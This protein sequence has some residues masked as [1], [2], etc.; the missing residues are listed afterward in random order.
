MDPFFNAARKAPHPGA[1]IVKQD[2]GWFPLKEEKRQRKTVKKLAMQ[3]EKEQLVKDAQ[4][5]RNKI[6]LLSQLIQSKFESNI[7]ALF[8]SNLQVP[9]P[10][11]SVSIL[12]PLLPRVVVAVFAVTGGASAL[13]LSLYI[14]DN[15]FLA[16]DS[17]EYE[18]STILKI[19]LWCLY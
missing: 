10:L 1:V 16:I 5:S 7:D 12:A 4:D 13:Q 19:I 6:V 9:L 3:H 14:L 11:P 15:P 8:S 2:A 17:K 18:L